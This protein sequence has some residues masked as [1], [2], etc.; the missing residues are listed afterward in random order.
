MKARPLAT[1]LRIVSQIRTPRGFAYDF[2]VGDQRL[3]IRIEA[4][5]TEGQWSVE[6]RARHLIHGTERVAATV[7]SSRAAGVRAVGDEWQEES[8]P[9]D[10]PAVLSLL[11]TVRA[12]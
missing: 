9:F 12:L 5:P 7:Q 2:A 10:W 6:G 8:L 11:E 4:A 3:T 1:E